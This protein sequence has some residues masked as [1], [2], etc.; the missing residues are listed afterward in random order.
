MDH[1]RNLE[2]WNKK[3]TYT[4][5]SNVETENVLM[6]ARLCCD[7]TQ[8]RQKLIQE[9]TFNTSYWGKH[10][11]CSFYTSTLLQLLQFLYGI[12]IHNL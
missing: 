12:Y 7:S 2:L 1:E 5:Y 11:V 4:L 8:S 9:F 3:P 6:G 10:I